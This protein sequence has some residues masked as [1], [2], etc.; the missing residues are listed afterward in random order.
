MVVAGVTG[1][2]AS[3]KTE[4]ARIFR[5][6]GARV[7]DADLA[8]RRALEKGRPAYRA[9]LRI[10]GRKFLGSNGEIDRKELAEHVFH[11]PRALRK[12]DILVHPQVIFD[13]LGWIRRLSGKKGVLVLD[14]PLLFESRM[15]GLADFTVVVRASRKKMLERARKKGIPFELAEKILSTQWPMEKKAR[16]ADFVMD[17]NGTLGDLRRKAMKIWVKINKQKGGK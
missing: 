10:W 5:K 14:V 2:L 13:C 3:G 9:L 16:L 15:E 17:N 11:H 1:N 4:V 8:A 7:F 6:L 12:L